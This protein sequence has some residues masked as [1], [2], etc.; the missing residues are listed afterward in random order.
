VLIDTGGDLCR[1]R[2]GVSVA[3]GDRTPW[4]ERPRCARPKWSRACP[5]GSLTAWP[6]V[7]VSLSTMAPPGS[8]CAVICAEIVASIVTRFVRTISC[9]SGGVRITDGQQ[10]RARLC[11]RLKRLREARSL[12]A[13]DCD[14]CADHHAI[15]ARSVLG[16]VQGSSLRSDRAC[17]RPSGLDGACAQIRCRPLRD[18]RRGD[19]AKLILTVDC[20][21]ERR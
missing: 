7:S 16:T 10:F 5:E 2:A 15:D 9:R 19:D 4:R 3:A 20:G 18:G 1:P 17:A 11:N 12:S 6:P 8:K 21:S 14:R 13:L